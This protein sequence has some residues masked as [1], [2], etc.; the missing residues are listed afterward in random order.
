MDAFIDTVISVCDYVKAK[1][2]SNKT[3]YLCV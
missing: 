2:R 1:K 3:M